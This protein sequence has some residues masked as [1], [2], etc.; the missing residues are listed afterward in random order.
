[1]PDITNQIGQAFGS[2]MSSEIVRLTTMTAFGYFVILWL[3]AAFWAFRDMHERTENPIVPY[4]AAGLIILFSPL[5]FVFGVIVYRIVRP[6][7]RLG[8]VYER[9]L[10]EEALLA[11]VE[12]IRTCPGCRRRVN[13]EWIICP[14]CR[15]RLNR[16]CPNCER[17]VGLDWSIC[18]WC[19]KD[20]EAPA[21]VVERSARRTETTPAPRS[22][23]SRQSN[24]LAGKLSTGR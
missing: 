2:F 19:A 17:L 21:Q 23:S 6:A 13:E 14:N 4:I 3:A 20:F 1:M 5:F 12:A 15:T 24:A 8:E 22:G 9:N 11:E 7:E 16:V 18:A 10:A